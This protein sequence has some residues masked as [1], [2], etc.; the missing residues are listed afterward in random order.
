MAREAV[1]AP[2]REC[3]RRAAILKKK[4]TTV[5]QRSETDSSQAQDQQRA[6]DSHQAAREALLNSFRNLRPVTSHDFEQ[7]I[8]FFLGEQ[9]SSVF[10]HFM[11]Y[12]NENHYD[13]SSSSDGDE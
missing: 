11:K 13:S 5:I 2:V 7:G 8:A 4:S 12:S 3:L 9:Q 6:N 1:M 10:G